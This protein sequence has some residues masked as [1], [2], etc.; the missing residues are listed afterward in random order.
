VAIPVLGSDP[1]TDAPPWKR[2]W[3][4]FRLGLRKWLIKLQYNYVNR[5]DY[6]DED[7]TFLNYGFSMLDEGPAPELEEEDEPNRMSIHLYHH[8]LS[9]VEVADKDVVE[10][11]CGRGGGAS[12]IARYF[13]PKSVTGVDLCPTTVQ[14]C[15]IRHRA[16]KLRFV[17]GDAEELLL[18]DASCD[19][20]INVESS[21]CYGRMQ[22]FLSE[23]FRILRPGGCFLLTDFRAAKDIEALEQRLLAT[24][25]ETVYGA[26]ISKNVIAAL[27]EESDR[28]AAFIDA[29]VPERRRQHFKCFAA[30]KG[31][32]LYADFVNGNI[33]YLAYVMRKPAE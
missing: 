1:L 13:S 22:Q 15:R 4:R 18:D 8:L 32:R 12:Y 28:K 26:D 3:V 9:Q 29:T 14:Y 10:I 20:V 21:H 23:V 11:G 6:G 7:L 30:V 2:W 16:P 27:D 33:Y 24:E 19:I 5:L 31:T 25:F 17:E